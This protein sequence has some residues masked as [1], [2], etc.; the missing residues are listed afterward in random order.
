M[1]SESQESPPLHD[2]K[3]WEHGGVSDRPEPARGFPVPGVWA[4]VDPVGV[5]PGKTVKL[6]ASVPSSYDVTFV[7]LGTTSLVDPSAKVDEHDDVEVLARRSHMVAS[8]QRISPG[9]YIFLDGPPPP[10]PP[11]TLG[12]WL[13]LWRPPSIDTLQWNWAGVITAFDYPKHCSFG[14]L[15][16]HMARPVFYWGDAADFSLEW[17][18]VPDVSLAGSIGRWRFLAATA[19]KEGVAL[20]VDGQ[21]VL[22]SSEPLPP[23]G[24]PAGRLRI[25]ASAEDGQAANFL[26][27]DISAPFVASRTLGAAELE[28]LASDGGRTPLAALGI[29]DLAGCWPLDEERGRH[30]ADASG[31]GRDGVIVNG[32]TWEIGGPG[33]D[34]GLGVPGYEPRRDLGRGHGL[35]LASDDLVDAEWPAVDEHTVA[36]DAPSGLYAA[37]IELPGQA[38]GDALEVPFVVVRTAPRRSGS[39]ALLVA[40]NTWHAYGRIPTDD[41]RIPGLSS[42]FYTRHL[43]GR[44]FFHL[45]LRLPIPYRA[46][47]PREAGAA[48]A[49]MAR[50]GWLRIRVP[51]RPR[52]A[53]APRCAPRLRRAPDLRSQRVLD[54]RHARGCR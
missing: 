8:R 5:E 42:S 53:P 6:H 7:K 12:V 37:R 44:P 3:R 11:L 22:R 13:R 31:N 18:H 45:G 36:S 27:A 38:R 21:E 54:R 48:R 50:R 49:S 32:A 33:F 15:V 34:A 39:I 41:I 28:R 17:L 47:S 1:R 35:R 20:F 30:V 19:G 23:G 25:G 51:D 43:S 4:Y 26:D 10:P 16:D 29:P 2:S 24:P 46:F 52:P 40:T 9:S 14:L